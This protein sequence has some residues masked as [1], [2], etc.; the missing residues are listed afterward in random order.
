MPKWDEWVGEERIQKDQ[1]TFASVRTAA[2]EFRRRIHAERRDTMLK[3]A[4]AQDAIELLPSNAP[5]PVLAAINEYEE[6]HRSSAARLIVPRTVKAFLANDWTIVNEHGHR[7]PFP[8]SPT[9]REL[10]VQ[11]TLQSVRPWPK[12]LV[13]EHM[14][15][16]LMLFNRSVSKCLL[17]EGEGEAYADS[18]MPLLQARTIGAPVR[19]PAD[20]CG[21]VHLLRFLLKMP[22]FVD[23]S[24]ADEEE[25]IVLLDLLSEI[26]L[27]LGP[28]L[29]QN[30]ANG[31]AATSDSSSSP[32]AAPSN[33]SS[34]VSQE[35]RGLARSLSSTSVSSEQNP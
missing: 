31:S 11:F 21:V 34:T 25:S 13:D 7:Y 16:L 8:A 10:L 23:A 28:L 30:L 19:T 1:G 35:F 27:F 15:G 4:E 20:V 9:M 24:D 5:N 12:R 29:E 26:L 17:Y 18:V 3:L 2:E 32:A 33:S 14:S 6:K 22:G